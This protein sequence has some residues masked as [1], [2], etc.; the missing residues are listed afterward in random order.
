MELESLGE[1]GGAF[2]AMAVPV[3]DPSSVD[4]AVLNREMS[5]DA[6]G[7]VFQNAI[8]AV[9]IKT[10]VGAAPSAGSC[11]MNRVEEFDRA[12]ARLVFV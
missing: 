8:A 1:L 2:L 5:R 3:R 11:S 10:P 9:W 7:Q 4:R 6:V 12:A